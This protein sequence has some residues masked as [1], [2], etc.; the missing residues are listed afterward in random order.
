MNIPIGQFYDVSYDFAV[1][2]NICSGAQDNGAWCGP[3][4]RR[5]T[6]INNNQWFTISG[7][8]GFYTAQDPTDPNMVWGESQG[9]GIQQTNLKTGERGR[10]N[11]PTWNEKYRAVG[12]F[13]RDRARR[14]AQAG[15]EGR[16]WRRSTRFASQQKKDSADLQI[17]YNWES[18]Y[19]LSPHNPQMFYLGGS[20]V[21]KSTKRGEDLY[22][23][24]P[25]LSIK[26]GSGAGARAS[27][28]ARHGR[29][30][31]RRHHAR[32]HR[33][34]GVRHGRRAAGVAAHAGPAARGHGQRQRLDDAQRRRALGE[35]DAQVRA[36]S[37][38]RGTRT[39]CGS[40]RATSIRSR[41][42]W[43]SRIIAGTTSRRICS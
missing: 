25:D 30:V 13:D 41:S 32:S 21:L 39:S 33:R 18:P 9:A 38:C 7:G 20:R 37:A 15:D 24:S 12:R 35:P 2:Y 4:K 6:P 36:R 22:P 34:R 11:K 27:R 40:S 42:T 10:V 26:T 19:F 43:R 28:A 5:N 29:E 17:R 16:A 14:S 23:I 3:S 31:H 8:D 1:P